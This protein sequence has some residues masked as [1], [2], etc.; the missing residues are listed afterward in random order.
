MIAAVL[1]AEVGAAKT[2]L[3]GM[4]EILGKLLTK[5]AAREKLVA[6]DMVWMAETS[7]AVGLDEA[8]EKQCQR[9]LTRLKE[10]PA[11]ASG[12]AAKAEPR[13]RSL[14]IHILG[15]RGKYEE[16]VKQAAT[17]IQAQ[18]QVPGAESGRMPPPPRLGHPEPRAVHPRPEGLRNPPQLV[19]S[20]QDEE[21]AGVLRSGL[22]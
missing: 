10:D 4:N 5:L 7:S 20:N 1:P 21:A 13:V 9:F 12:G 22:L 11:F 19:G 14:L 8:A 18:P 2:R 17:L 3:A 6:A 15:K 16:A